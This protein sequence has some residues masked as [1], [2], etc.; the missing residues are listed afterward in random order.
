MNDCEMSS[1]CLSGVKFDRYA[2]DVSTASNFRDHLNKMKFQSTMN[3]ET[4]SVTSR[5]SFGE[6]L[7]I[8]KA[9][10]DKSIKDSPS[11]MLYS[12][13]KEQSVNVNNQQF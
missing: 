4:A 2:T 11:G 8:K 12:Q 7:S 13:L 10:R 6:R 5:L 3:D 1:V 9:Q